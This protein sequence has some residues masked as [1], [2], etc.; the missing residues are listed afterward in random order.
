MAT[1]HVS[2]LVAIMK[3]YEPSLTASQA[4]MLLREHEASSL[5]DIEAIIADLQG[6]ET[7]EVT[8]ALEESAEEEAVVEEEVI[9]ETAEDIASL[10][11][12]LVLTPEIPEE[13]P[14]QFLSFEDDG[15]S[16]QNISIEE[17]TEGMTPVEE[18]LYNPNPTIEVDL[19][20]E[21]N[22]LDE[23]LYDED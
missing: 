16:V 12:N 9:S 7:S 8:I 22:S 6:V 20:V 1:P 4:K 3:H 19:G 2:G 21:L 10:E 17:F 18:V 23:D 5:A 14:F 15:T 11:P 13:I